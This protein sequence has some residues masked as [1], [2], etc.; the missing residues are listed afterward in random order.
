MRASDLEGC[1]RVVVFVKDD[2]GGARNFHV[3]IEDHALK[4]L[5]KSL[6]GFVYRVGRLGDVSS[7]GG[8]RL[9]GGEGCDVLATEDAAAHRLHDG[10]GVATHGGEKVVSRS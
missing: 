10:A 4:F 2:C 8:L 6:D 1:R 3:A 7:C 9:E 5:W